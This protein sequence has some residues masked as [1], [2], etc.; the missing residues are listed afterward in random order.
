MMDA[1]GVSLKATVGVVSQ[2][3]VVVAIAEEFR[4][5]CLQIWRMMCPSG[6]G[7]I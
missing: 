5:L 4:E 2:A 3:E 6:M 1:V 7:V